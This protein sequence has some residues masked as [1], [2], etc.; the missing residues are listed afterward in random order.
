MYK[1]RNLLARREILRYFF[2]VLSLLLKPWLAYFCF[3]LTLHNWFDFWFDKRCL[4]SSSLLS[5]KENLHSIHTTKNNTR[6]KTLLS[7]VFFTFH[8]VLSS[9]YRKGH[10][11]L[12]STSGKV[13]LCVLSFFF[14]NLPQNPC[15]CYSRV[16]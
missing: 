10:M 15:I 9:I 14:I 6:R 4:I 1:K 7:R 12:F 11:A 13:I 3:V 5:S 16:Q 8:P 2:F